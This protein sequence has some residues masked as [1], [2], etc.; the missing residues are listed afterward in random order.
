MTVVK[1]VKKASKTPPIPTSVLPSEKPHR[2]KF[3]KFTQVSM[4]QRVLQNP[5]VGAFPRDVISTMV[6]SLTD[7]TKAMLVHQTYP[8]EFEPFRM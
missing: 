2:I 3:L 8:M 5:R 6:V 7:E 1:G 4:S